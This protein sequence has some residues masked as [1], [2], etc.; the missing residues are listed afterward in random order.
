MKGELKDMSVSAS[1]INSNTSSGQKTVKQQY[2]KN[3]DGT[4]D[5][6][7]STQLRTAV[8]TTTLLVHTCKNSCKHLPN[9]KIAGV[10]KSNTC[11]LI[12]NSNKQFQN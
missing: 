2:D 6:N 5:Q 7:E 4:L 11:F 12:D 9:N 1:N 10:L 3:N 8:L